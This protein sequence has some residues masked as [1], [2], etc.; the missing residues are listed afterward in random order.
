[1]AIAGIGVVVLRPTPGA[2]ARTRSALSSDAHFVNGP[3]AGT[4]FA[5]VST[6]LMADGRRCQHRHGAGDRRC[7]VRLS[8]AA[9]SAVTAFTVAGCTAPGVYRARTAMLAYV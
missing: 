1:L 6:W 4:T 3:K 9:Y 7:Q 5:N 2:L 8:A